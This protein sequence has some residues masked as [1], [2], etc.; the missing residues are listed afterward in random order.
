MW[1]LYTVFVF[2]TTT[3]D[4]ADRVELQVLETQ[5]T[6]AAVDVA[7]RLSTFSLKVARCYDPNEESK[8]LNV[9]RQCGEA[10]F[11]AHI[12]AALGELAQHSLNRNHGGLEPCH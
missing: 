1:E 8:I 12:R 4:A 3:Q 9:I 11:E 6:P 7:E 10:R 5:R 2:A